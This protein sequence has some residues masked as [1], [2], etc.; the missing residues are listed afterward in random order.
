MDL[1]GIKSITI[2]YSNLKDVLARTTSNPLAEEELVGLLR[3]AMS[4]GTPVF[5]RASEFGETY[6]LT[7]EDGRYKLEPIA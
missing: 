3:K 6:K 1:K 4:G 5:V 2:E 7:L